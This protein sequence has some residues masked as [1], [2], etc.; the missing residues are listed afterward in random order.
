MFYGAIDTTVKY[1]DSL[2]TRDTLD[3]EFNLVR[4][5]NTGINLST[6]VYG[7]FPVNMFGVTAIRHTLTPTVGYTFLPKHE[8]DRA[9]YNVGIGYGGLTGPRAKAEQSV[10]FSL[11]N[12]F[13]GKR[14]AGAGPA[15]RSGLNGGKSGNGGNGVNG[16]ISGINN[17]YGVSG[18]GVDDIDGIDDSTVTV[19][20]D[21]VNTANNKERRR[22][23][24]FDILT[25]SMSTAYNAEAELRRWR[26]LSL[27]AGT[28]I[29]ILNVSFSSSFWFYDK[30]DSLIFPAISNYSVDL[31]S[32]RLGVSGRFWDGDLLEFGLTNAADGGREGGQA[33]NIGFSPSLSY[34]ASRGS[35]SE[36]FEPAK[37]FNVSSS[38]SVNLTKS[39]SARW[40]GN[41]DFSS[42]RFS[43][44]S[45]DFHYDMECWEMRFSWRPERI[46]PGFSFVVNVKKMP[47]IKWEQKDSRSTRVL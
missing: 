15:G 30:T 47:D 20:A 17:G 33:W 24:K 14:I 19:A 36:R 43:H 13:Q 8:L 10:S 18:D 34:R 9:F 21:T 42:D 26:D 28:G 44:N 35:L 4:S 39:F 25:V 31:T 40:N 41:Y 5:W 1:V 11:S 6:R 38:A 27:N 7:L 2:P 16:I 37:S 32:G 46:N 3:T 12:T 45:F 22:E 23:E 29:G